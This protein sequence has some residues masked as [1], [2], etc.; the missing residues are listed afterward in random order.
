VAVGALIVPT[1]AATAGRGAGAATG[2]IF[3]PTRSTVNVIA[4]NALGMPAADL[5]GAFGPEEYLS[6]T[7][8]FA[9]YDPGTVSLAG[10]SSIVTFHHSIEIAP[11]EWAGLGVYTLTRFADGSHTP[12]RHGFS[13]GKGT[14]ENTVGQVNG[15]IL[16]VYEFKVDLLDSYDYQ[17]HVRQGYA[18]DGWG[19]PAIAGEPAGRGASGGQTRATAAATGLPHGVIVVWARPSDPPGGDRTIWGALSTDDAGTF[20]VPFQITYVGGADLMNP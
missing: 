7:S 17:V 10:G 11:D 13:D 2:D 12:P 1:L 4:T 9:A 5:L 16:D 19:P 14:S 18:A 8:A 3:R 6:G 15:Q 20:G